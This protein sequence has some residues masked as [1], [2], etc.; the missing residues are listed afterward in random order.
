VEGKLVYDGDGWCI[1]TGSFNMSIPLH[2]VQC[3]MLDASS[4]D[5]ISLV[6][7]VY[8]IS[9]SKYSDSVYASIVES[10]DT[11]LQIQNK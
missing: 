8:E 4:S 1:L 10:A 3:D 5:S 2:P 11:K 9:L 7:K 6:N